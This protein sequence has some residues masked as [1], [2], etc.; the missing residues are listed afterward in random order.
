[1]VDDETMTVAPKAVQIGTLVGSKILV[2]GGLEPG[3]GWK[4]GINQR[5]D[6]V[7]EEFIT[8]RDAAI[9]TSAPLGTTLDDKANVGH[10]ID[11]RSATIPGLWKRISVIHKSAA[12]ADG[13]ST[14]FAVMGKDEITAAIKHF[15]GA[16]VIAIDSKG[17]R[18]SLS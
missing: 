18:L 5:E 11:P 13:L 15:T 1:M 8:L 12:I 6:Q 10:I 14:A 16:R 2:T 9:A 17:Q 7:P 3:E 4:I